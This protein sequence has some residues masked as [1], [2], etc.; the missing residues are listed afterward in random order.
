[1]NCQHHACRLA[2]AARLRVAGLDPSAAH[3]G[4]V[5]CRIEEPLHRATMPI[6]ALRA[7]STE[8][9]RPKPHNDTERK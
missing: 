5:P 1:M 7:P 3:R 6:I 2:Y 9:G 4:W 8:A